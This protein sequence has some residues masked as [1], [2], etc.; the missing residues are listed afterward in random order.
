MS[1]YRTI[2]PLVTLRLLSVTIVVLEGVVRPLLPLVKWRPTIGCVT[3][4]QPNWTYFKEIMDSQVGV[5]PPTDPIC[6]LFSSR[7]LLS[8]EVLEQ[9]IQ[10]DQNESSGL[11]KLNVKYVLVHT[12]L[13]LLA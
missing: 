4:Y 8:I 3:K 6:Y 9:F 2:G 5:P 12:V 7:R 1:V 11:S 10:L 13:T